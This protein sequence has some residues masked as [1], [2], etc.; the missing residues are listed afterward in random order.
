MNQEGL[1]DW[2]L[3]GIIS[4]IVAKLLLDYYTNGVFQHPE[5]KGKVQ[6]LEA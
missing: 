5:I 1:I 6:S 2:C 4:W 3:S